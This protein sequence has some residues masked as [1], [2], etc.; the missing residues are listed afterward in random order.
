MKSMSEFSDFREKGRIYQ[1]SFRM[2]QDNS[3]L[4]SSATHLLLPSIQTRCVSCQRVYT[5]LPMPTANFT[6]HHHCLHRY[7]IDTDNKRRKHC[8]RFWIKHEGK[9][10]G[11][12][13]TWRH[14][15]SVADLGGAPSTHP[16]M[17]QNFLNF[18][19]FFR[20]YY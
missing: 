19:G 16:P 14:L 12:N 20:K 6:K 18:I 10:T 9:S 5:G 2:F 11:T 8:S 13:L 7:D 17:D 4:N 1:C 3:V 15:D